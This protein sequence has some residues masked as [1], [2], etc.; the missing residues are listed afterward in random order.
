MIL[1]LDV[2]NSRIKWRLLT[3]DTLLPL[4][5]GHVPGFEE[6]QQLPQLESSLSL[7]RMCSVRSGEVNRQIEDWIKSKFNIGLQQAS[8]TRSC[9]GVTNQYEDVSRLGIDRWLAM[10]AAFRKAEGACIVID[11]GTAFTVDVVDVQGMHLGGYI[12]PGLNLMWDSLESNT[13]IR[14]AED[15]SSYSLDLGQST[16]EAV[17]NGT[18]SALVATINTVSRS[19]SGEGEAKVYFTGGD[20]ELLHGLAGIEGSEIA[21]SLVFDGLDVACP[22]VDTAGAQA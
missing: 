3:A 18:V 8:V 17:F 12:I 5:E 4:S 22:R 15:F 21:L 9:G 11:S 16:D 1:E 7:A 10:L 13:A 14:L 19:L 20:A 6:L 2:G